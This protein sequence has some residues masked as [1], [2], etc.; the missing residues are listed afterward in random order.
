MG[1]GR[2]RQR[3]G[4]HEAGQRER[5]SGHERDARG[6]RGRVEVFVRLLAAREQEHPRG[7]A[8]EPLLT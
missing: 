8:I 6:E 2:Q 4:D 1:R 5:Q 7:V 3:H